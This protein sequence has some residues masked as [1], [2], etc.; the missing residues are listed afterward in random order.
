MEVQFYKPSNETLRKYIEGFYFIN[1]KSIAKPIKY[2]TFPNNYC[3]AAV[4]Q[5]TNLILEKNRIVV[6]AS[7]QENIDSSL[8]SRYI[9][10]I[11]IIQNDVTD[12]ITIYFKPLGLN[13]FVDDIQVLF[14][15][16]IVSFNPFVDYK[17]AMYKIFNT[18]DR[19]SQI[20]QLEDYWLSKLILRDF[21]LVDRL[22]TDIQSDLKL[23]E[24]A[25]KHHISRQYLNKIFIKHIG[26][27]PS[28]FR[29]IQRFRNSISEKQKAGSLTELSHLTQF[30]DQSHFIR[31][32]RSFTRFKPSD[33]F[34]RV[35]TEKE[36]VWLVF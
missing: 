17:D 34:N 1:K 30:Y 10:P 16:N 21:S 35:D 27:S 32:F 26:K 3:I 22:I 33:F 4:Y 6:S 23:N 20:R 18:K 8:V 19:D 13:Q 36:N 29:K 24:V 15:E 9:L 11:E 25:K 12:E 14:R 7:E 28:E 2:W 5:N 31:D